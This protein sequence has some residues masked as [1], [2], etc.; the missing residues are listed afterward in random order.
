MEI[1]N[2]D[3]SFLLGSREFKKDENVAQFIEEMTKKAGLVQ[4]NVLAEILELNK[5]VEYLKRFNLDGAMDLQTFKS[6]IPVV[7]YEDIRPDIRRIADGDQSDILTA[8]PISEFLI[9]SGTSDCERK[10]IPI[11]KQ[12]LARRQLLYSVLIPGVMNLSFSGLLEGK[13]LYFY[14]VKPETR[15]SGGLVAQ[16]ATSHYFRS[17]NFKSCLYNA[18]IY[19]SPIESILCLDSYQSMYSQ[20][21]C[22]LLERNQ[23]VRIGTIFASSLLRAISFLQLNWQDLLQDIMSGTLNNR[24]TDPSIRERLDKVMKPDRELAEFIESECSKDNWKG[25]ITRIWPNAKYIDVTITGG[26]AQHIPTLD[27]YSGGLPL[28][29]TIYASSECFFGL[30]LNPF[31]KPSEV[32]YT[33]MPNMAYFEFLPHEPNSCGLNRESP[34]KLVNLA[35]VEVGKEYEIVVTTFAGL[36]RYRVDDILRVTGFHNSAPQFHFVGR[37]NVLLGIDINEAE[38]QNSIENASRLLHECNTSVTDYTCFAD[39]NTNPGHFVIYL[40]LSMNNS[41]ESLSDDVLSQCC[42]ATE[43]SLN[44]MY[45]QGRFEYY[46]IGPLEIRVVKK[47][48]FDEL[49]D[50]VVSKGASMNQYKVPRFVSSTPIIELLD[51]RVVSSHFSPSLPHWNP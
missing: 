30:N 36:Y 2:N 9:S 3:I 34:P 1:E 20:M 49:M 50:F 41:A 25:I 42:Y 22:G 8:Y 15:T 37:K 5:N 12:E 4:E 11:T 18:N 24:I 29:S 43:E 45:R 46:W 23:V 16:P 38:L 27:Y 19:T 7:N 13:G 40:E 33:I 17:D 48:A 10:L 47:G 6:K 39:T 31:C 21:L 28:V 51:S 32:S 44:S 26:M 35:D 14:Y